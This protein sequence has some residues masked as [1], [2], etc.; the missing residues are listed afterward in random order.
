MILGPPPS[1]SEAISSSSSSSLASFR[2]PTQQQQQ[3]QPDATTAA[4]TTSAAAAAIWTVQ[5]PMPDISQMT[6]PPSYAESLAAN[7]IAAH[8]CRTCTR[9]QSSSPHP[10]QH[11]NNGRATSPAVIVSRHCHHH[12]QQQQR[13]QQPGN[14]A[15]VDAAVP[16][17]QQQQQ[18][19][20]A[21]A[22]VVSRNNVLPPSTVCARHLHR[23]PSRHRQI[24]NSSN[25]GNGTSIQNGRHAAAANG[26]SLHLVFPADRAPGTTNRNA[27]IRADAAAVDVERDGS[28]NTTACADRYRDIFL[29]ILMR[30]LLIFLFVV[31]MRILI[32]QLS[33]TEET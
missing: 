7:A 26:T 5:L 29:S 21:S 2:A 33:P 30:I 28:E 16:L 19:R 11:G 4:G 9:Q 18:Q 6:P 31:F 13:Q 20:S 10:H 3:A 14:A 22:A 23:C 15:V 8:R 32:A 24:S 27:Q 12:Q 17:P 25:G 1:Y